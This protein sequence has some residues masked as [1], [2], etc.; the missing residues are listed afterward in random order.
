MRVLALLFLALLATPAMASG[1]HPLK[2]E[3]VFPSLP[4]K[5]R[6]R[7]YE[8][9]WKWSEFSPQPEGAPV[10]LFFYER[11]RAVA[12][13]ARPLIAD[14]YRDFVEAFGYV[15]TQTIPFLLYNSHFEFEST[16]A[17]FVSE[18]VLGVT[19][20]EDLTVALPYWGEHQRFEHVMRHELAHQFT[21]QQVLDGARAARCNPL[22]QMPLWF[23]EGIAETYSQAGLT[24]DV[25]AAIAD[26]LLAHEGDEPEDLPDFFSEG[27]PS[28]ERVY[29]L[30]HAQVRFLE[31]RF[32][33]G[34]VR[35]ILTAAPRLCRPMQQF[36]GLLRSTRDPFARLIAELTGA[37]PEAIDSAWK[38]WAREQ[39]QP[40]LRARTPLPE[41]TLMEGLGK[42]MFDSF[43]L[44]PDGRILFYR[45]VDLDSG[46]ARLYLRDL[47]DPESEVLIT[48][49]QRIG[50]VSLHPMDRRVTA[51]GRDMLA[52]IGRVGA[53]DV[54]VVRRYT[55]E[56]QG[57][58][59]R[60][61][62]GEKL[63]LDLSRFDGLLEGGHPAISPAG[64][65]AFIGLR[66]DAGFLDIY[67][68]NAPFAREAA[69]VQLTNDRYAEQGLS[70]G[71][72]GALYFSSDATPD[73][74]YAV[75]RLMEGERAALVLFPGQ[76]DATGPAAGAAGLFFESG[77]TGWTQAYQATEGA[78]F[79]LTDVPTSFAGP[80][81]A[82]DGSLLGVVQVDG[83]Q[84]L[85]RLPR[86]RWLREPAPGA[87]S[88]ALTLEGL[89]GGGLPVWDIPQTPIT[90]EQDYSPL[91]N[92]S[93]ESAAG[94]ISPGP[95]I[96][97]QL[98][99]A[100]PLNTHLIG[101]SALVLEEFDRASGELTYVDLSGR[102]AVGGG[103]F[104]STSL[105]L[106]GDMPG[107]SGTYFLQ[108]YGA[109]V[110]AEYPFGRYMR[111]QG[112]LAPQMLR[113]SDFSNPVG[114][115]ARE[116]SGTH[117]ALQGG[118][119]FALDTT[120]L[121]AVG[122]YDGL[123]FSVGTDGTLPVAGARPFANVSAE[124][125]AYK[126]L[127][128]GYE[129]LFVHGRL[130]LGTALGGAFRE[131]FYLP[132]EQNLRALESG[133]L[134]VLGDHYYLG[135][136]ELHF[137]LLPE[138]GGIYLQGLVGVDLGAIFF[139]Y[140]ALLRERQAAGVLGANLLLGPLSLRLHFA[141]PFDIGA[142][143]RNDRWLTHFSLGTPFT[144]L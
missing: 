29:L 42:G 100:D 112:F 139:D 95:L 101:M 130:A 12:E 122:P 68:F 90:Q 94:V 61:R 110:L 73:G 75:F 74:S 138:L 5:S 26:V 116:N 80:S 134:S 67:Q 49:D 70:Y 82:Y 3:T 56:E 120:R 143:I 91:R 11:E 96:A 54:L 28:F 78:I 36:V 89:G 142:G 10:R 13:V 118:A 137:P 124:L 65:V 19:S 125:L 2:L 6:V 15:P 22:T 60:L 16:R 121:S 41:L 126:N 87:G 141:R 14:A 123:A 7:W 30:G 85:A 107:I 46:V 140:E 131:S 72:D 48:Q 127:V 136:A 104:A 43:S 106:D 21:I 39:V 86:E 111:L 25:R 57:G 35:R 20:T 62:L 40:A 63:S 44:S 119:S 92:L 105:Q 144:L 47:A 50:M 55:R 53:S 69:P 135:Q 79:R 97:T 33:P 31:Q 38:Q 34:L 99:F 1:Q 51:V 37:S 59:V 64:A 103:I 45:T 83:R 27:L 52:Y 84:R 77:A 132:A 102:T 115:L 81:V 128:P 66:R 109:R 58:R 17:F 98:L 32:G 9:D 24:P 4:G 23:I 113:A 129:R 133:S 8:F 108:R 71:P 76:G 114:A 88:P 117:A 18:T 93:L